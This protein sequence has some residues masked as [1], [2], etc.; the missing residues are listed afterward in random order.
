MCVPTVLLREPIGW[1]ACKNPKLEQLFLGCLD[2][3][4]DGGSGGNGIPSAYNA[5]V[6]PPGGNGGSG[7]PSANNNALLPG[8]SG[9]SGIPS[10]TSVRGALFVVALRL[11]DELA[12]TTM[13]PASTARPESRETFLKRI[14]DTSRRHPLRCLAKTIFGIQNVPITEQ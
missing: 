1:I 5:A 4:T 13:N 8:G 10:A 11:T 9:G 12:G 7:I 3:T 6:F 14:G 2:H